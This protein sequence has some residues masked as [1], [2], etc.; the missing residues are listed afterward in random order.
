MSRS[1][2]SPSTLC[3][4]TV[5]DGVLPHDEGVFAIVRVVTA[6]DAARLETE[7]L[8]ERDR[9]RVRHAHLEGV[10]TPR[11]ARRQ[12]EQLVEEAAGDSLTPVGRVNREVHDVPRV[13]VAR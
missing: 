8:V 1:R 11:V 6:P 3:D 4:F 9:A 7:P 10:A 12:L 2:V 13:H 5:S